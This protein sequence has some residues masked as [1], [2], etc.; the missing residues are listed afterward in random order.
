MVYVHLTSGEFKFSIFHR[1]CMPVSHFSR[2]SSIYSAHMR[3]V[4]G[5]IFTPLRPSV[6]MGGDHCNKHK[7]NLYK[8]IKHSPVTTNANQ[9]HKS[10]TIRNHTSISKFKTTNY[11][12]L[13]QT[14]NKFKTTS[15]EATSLNYN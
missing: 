6:L 12:S 2:N 10:N 14:I 11:K 13:S 8:S 15:S 1:V 5:K 4:N 3:R 9:T 7:S